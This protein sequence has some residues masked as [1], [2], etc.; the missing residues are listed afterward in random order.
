MLKLWLVITRPTR[1]TQNSATLID[2]IYISNNLQCSFDSLIL[3]EDISDHLPT[4]ALLKQTKMSDK[5][6]IEIKECQNQEYKQQVK[7]ERLEW[8]LKL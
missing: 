1:I 8:N 2:N 7:P 6:P 3:I 4:V 5:T